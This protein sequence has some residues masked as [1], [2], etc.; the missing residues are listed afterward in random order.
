MNEVARTSNEYCDCSKPEPALV[1]HGLGSLCEKCYR[2]IG[3]PSSIERLGIIKQTPRQAGIDDIEWLCEEVERLR[4]TVAKYG[5]HASNCAYRLAHYKARAPACDCG[6]NEYVAGLSHETL[7]VARDPCR[8]AL[9]IGLLERF[10]DGRISSLKSTH[11]SI[12]GCREQLEGERDI[13]G[14][15]IDA[16]RTLPASYGASEKAGASLCSCGHD[17]PV[18]PG[19]QGNCPQY[20]A[21]LPPAV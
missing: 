16:L 9:A 12:L 6:W 20:R 5:D 21:R 19:H 4:G 10:R 11:E 2:P 13:F 17:G 18:G 3:N 7:A 14:Y 15:A 8:V 1:D